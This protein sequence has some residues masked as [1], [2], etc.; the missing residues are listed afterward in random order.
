MANIMRLGSGSKKT[1]FPELNG[2]EFKTG[3]LKTYSN[4]STGA[5]YSFD[6]GIIPV[7]ISCSASGSNSSDLGSTSRSCTINL[8]LSD[9]SSI[10]MFTFKWN[11]NNGTSSISGNSS[12][13][14]DIMQLLN[15]DEEKVKMISG[16]QIVNTW[17]SVN[18]T[19]SSWL[20]KKA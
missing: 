1:L 9:G 5:T 17:C 14:I 7:T 2:Y 16:I 12:G 10:Q 13:K 11:R 19:I 3:S 15:Y 8:K 18:A 20:E 6:E 4:S